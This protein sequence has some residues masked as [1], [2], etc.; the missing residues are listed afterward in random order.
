[1]FKNNL[2]ITLTILK[3]K[4]IFSAITIL[5]IAVPLMFLMIIIST[6]SHIASFD[7][8]QTNFDR[9]L[10]LDQIKFSIKRTN[11]M[12]GDLY[13]KPTYDFVKKYVKPMQSPEKIGVVSERKDYN[14]YIENEKAK[15][16]V[17]YTDGVFWEIADFKLKK[18]KAF[19]TADVESSQLVAVIDEYTRKL[20][21]GDENAVGK[22][23][24]F[25]RKNYKIIGVVENVDVTRRWTHS[26]VYL[27]VTTS[28]VYSKKDILTSGIYCF[29]LA[30]SKENIPQIKAEFD[31]MIDNFQL[32][33]YEGLTK[34]D[35]ELRSD[36]F[37]RALQSFISLMQL[38]FSFSSCCP[39]SI[40]YIYISAG[41]MND[42]P[43]LASENH[44]VGIKESCPANLSLKTY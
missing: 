20:V 41:L 13:A 29:L 43:K 44:L 31:Y 18:G 5:G 7:S 19:N 3:R 9:V 6:V 25:F 10:L 42:H 35:G 24:K 14:L 8:P 30:G 28:E 17:V 39:L 33:N 27:P 16:K 11:S 2:K 38:S 34:I 15:L 12:S 23:I 1:M 37:N 22:T 26:N 21:F 40:Y 36:T 32:G 4:K